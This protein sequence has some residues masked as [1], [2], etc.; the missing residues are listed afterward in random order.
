MSRGREGKRQGRPPKCVGLEAPLLSVI[1]LITQGSFRDRSHVR[2]TARR[3]AALVKSQL[4]RSVLPAQRSSAQR[5]CARRDKVVCFK[6]YNSQH[7]NRAELCAELCSE[8]RSVS[9]RLLTVTF[10]TVS[11]PCNRLVREVSP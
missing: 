10:N 2:W 8:T 6:P 4:T 3:R 5:M 9:A 7:M 11:C 1:C